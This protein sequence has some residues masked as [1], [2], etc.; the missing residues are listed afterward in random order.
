MSN[1]HKQGALLGLHG[2]PRDIVM[3]PYLTHDKC[4]LNVCSR[5]GDLISET[6]NGTDGL[7]E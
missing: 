5:K 1:Y 6:L 2:Q 4:S 3:G 7:L